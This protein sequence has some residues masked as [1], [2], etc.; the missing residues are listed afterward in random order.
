VD[1][2]TPMLQGFWLGIK[3]FFGMWQIWL[4]L[5][6]FA[7]ITSLPSLY[8]RWRLSQAGMDEVDKMGGI[9][10]EQYL[11]GLFRRLGYQVTR[12]RPIGD[13]G[14]DLVLSGKGERIVVQAKR[15]SK[16]VGNKAVQEVVASRPMYK[17]DRAMVVSNQEFTSAAVELAQANQVELWGRRKLADVILSLRRA[18]EQKRPVEPVAAAKQAVTPTPIVSAAPICDRCGKPMVR[19]VSAKGPFYGCSGYPRCRNIKQIEAKG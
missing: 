2:V 11:E 8:H 9:E 3:L 19:R 14:A 12:T 18:P 7:F 6:A 10:F 1:V 13:Q 16:R 4:P 15:W 17:C 5:L